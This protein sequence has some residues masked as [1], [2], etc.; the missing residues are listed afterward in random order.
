MA[1]LYQSFEDL[2]LPLGHAGHLVQVLEL[3]C[4]GWEGSNARSVE[5]PPLKKWLLIVDQE[6][7]QGL[8]CEPQLYVWPVHRIVS[9][10]YRPRCT[11]STPRLQVPGHQ[12]ILLMTKAVAVPKYHLRLFL[13]L[14]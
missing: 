1:A 10:A 3:S 5:A 8:Y 11:V 13:A 9:D 6:A 14:A 7:H 12:L 4:L 2:F